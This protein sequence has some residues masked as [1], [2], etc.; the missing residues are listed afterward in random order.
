MNT[1]DP[2]PQTALQAALS[3]EQPASPRPAVEGLRWGGLGVFCRLLE[4]C[5]GEQS[6]E[7]CL[8]SDANRTLPHGAIGGSRSR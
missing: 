7:F 5:L 1:T 6:P 3:A 8:R 2:N 4:D